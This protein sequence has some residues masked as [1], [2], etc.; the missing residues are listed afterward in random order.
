M[1][2]PNLPNSYFADQ[3]EQAHLEAAIWA[4][5]PVGTRWHNIM[6]AFTHMLQESTYEAFKARI[7]SGRRKENKGNN[8]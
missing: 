7:F 5:I 1:K 4:V 2:L 8:G 6:L 3:A